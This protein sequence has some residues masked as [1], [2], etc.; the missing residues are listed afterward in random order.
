MRWLP[1]Y[2]DVSTRA[3][4]RALLEDVTSAVKTATENTGF[5]VMAICKD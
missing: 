1:A 4:E 5:C 3:D 2:E